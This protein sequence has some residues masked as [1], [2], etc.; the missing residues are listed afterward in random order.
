CSGSFDQSREPP[1]GFDGALPKPF[2]LEE[3]R[4]VLGE[5]LLR[6]AQRGHPAP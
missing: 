5:V 4:R 6:H 2:N 3:A 1:E